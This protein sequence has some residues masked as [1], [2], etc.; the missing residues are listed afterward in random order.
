MP[1]AEKTYCGKCDGYGKHRRNPL[2]PWDE[3]DDCGGT[4]YIATVNDSL[5]VE[6]QERLDSL[7]QWT[8]DYCPEGVSGMPESVQWLMKF[9]GNSA[10]SDI[11]QRLSEAITLLYSH[12]LITEAMRT[13]ARRKL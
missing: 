1:N 4:G 10:T 9:A 7:R 2:C 13:H 11:R 12:G 8:E 3:C 6:A 5:T